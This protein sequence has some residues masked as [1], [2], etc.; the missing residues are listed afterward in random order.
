[1]TEAAPTRLERVVGVLA[2]AV[3]SLWVGG[4][5]TLVANTFTLDNDTIY[6]WGVGAL[7]A[8]LAV[9]LVI[10]VAVIG[11]V[12]AKKVRGNAGKDA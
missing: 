9:A 5:A 6:V 7:R 12:I 1:M 8:G 4:F 11:S 10:V 3:I 2:R